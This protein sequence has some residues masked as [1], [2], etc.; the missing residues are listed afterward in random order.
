MDT[1]GGDIEC[2][3]AEVASNPR[4]ALGA[5]GSWPHV[6]GREGVEID[7]SRPPR[8]GDRAADFFYLRLREGWYAMRN[9]TNGIGVAMSFPI[10]VYPYLW[11][12][13]DFNGSFGWPFYG[14]AYVWG[15]ELSSSV[16]L[17]G[18]AAAVE[19]GTSRVIPPGESVSADILVVLCEGSRPVANVDSSGS[20][21]YR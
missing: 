6:L 8:E 7:V 14:R 2:E 20:V 17:L 3:P 16:P 18:L 10:D 9:P 4:I 15:V 5:K 11:L 1:A 13:Q 12:W 21:T 19:R